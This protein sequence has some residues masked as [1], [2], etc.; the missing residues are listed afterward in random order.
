MLLQKNVYTV[1]L[2]MEASE[3]LERGIEKLYTED[4]DD[5][6]AVVA[7]VLLPATTTW[8]LVAGKV[9]YTHCLN[10]EVVRIGSDLKTLQGWGGGT[11]T[12]QRWE[13]WQE[14]LHKFTERD[15]MNEECRDM[16]LKTLR[17]MAEIEA[18]YEGR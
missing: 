10:N 5:I 17:K 3:A 2:P 9:I 11:W 15:D 12:I 1:N 18:E 7:Q 14:R 13:A 8:L 16:V 6:N 4:S